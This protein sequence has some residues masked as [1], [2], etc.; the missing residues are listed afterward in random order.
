MVKTLTCPKCGAIDF[1]TDKIGKLKCVHCGSLVIILD[2][3]LRKN[4]YSKV[5]LTECEK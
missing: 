5:M 3:S 1:E 2:C 4:W